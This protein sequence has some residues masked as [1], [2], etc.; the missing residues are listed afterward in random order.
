[1]CVVIIPLCTAIEILLVVILIHLLHKHHTNRH[2]CVLLQFP[3]VQLLS[4][5]QLL[6]LFTCCINIIQTDICVCVVTIPLCTAIE[7]LLFVI[8]FHLLHKH[9]RD[10]YM[11]V[12]LQLPCVQL[13]RSYQLLSLFTCCI[14]IIRTDIY[15]C[16]YNSLVY[17]Y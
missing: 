1:M 14:N 16:C 15:M 5:D 3:C 8:A 4:S 13:L 17:S 10:R 2:I 9:H 11:C 6:S 12:L 7:T